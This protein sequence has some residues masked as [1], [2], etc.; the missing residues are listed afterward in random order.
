M[1]N[2]F[3]QI[4]RG[5]LALGVVVT[6]AAGAI[7]GG[8]LAGG[9]ARAPGYVFGGLVGLLLAALVFGVAA[10]VF[11]MQRSLRELADA[12]RRATRPEVSPAPSLSHKDPPTAR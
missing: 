6:V 1:L 2:A 12:A 11:D 7:V 4:A 10:A 9:N 3:I 8:T 5:L